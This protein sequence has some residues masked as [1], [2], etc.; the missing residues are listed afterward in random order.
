MSKFTSSSS[1]VHT[2]INSMNEWINKK[3]M[4]KLKQMMILSF[5]LFNF[6]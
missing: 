2:L 6:I 5:L 1:L 3:Q 4:K